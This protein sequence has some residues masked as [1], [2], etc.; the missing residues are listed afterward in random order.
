MPW[1]FA[2][3]FILN[4][5]DSGLDPFGKSDFGS[6]VPS[7]LSAQ[8][9]LPKTFGES[10]GKGSGAPFCRLLLIWGGLRLRLGVGSSAVGL[11]ITCG[12]K[13]PEV[14][15][16]VAR[17]SKDSTVESIARSSGFSLDLVLVIKAPNMK[18][19]TGGSEGPKY[20]V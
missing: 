10:C 7:R 18:R 14:P 11:P 15:L 2:G 19:C 5:Y 16:S 8:L 12:I 9:T 1:R 17:V 3:T 13:F 20:R 6:E 4:K